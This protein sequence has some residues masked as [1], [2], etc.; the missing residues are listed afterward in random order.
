MTSLCN[1]F[2]IWRQIL[3][4]SNQVSTRRES[5]YL[6]YNQRKSNF[7]LLQMLVFVVVVIIQHIS[8]IFHKEPPRVKETSTFTIEPLAFQNRHLI[9][10]IP[11]FWL[12]LL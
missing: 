12:E 5:Q 10:L 2:E 9:V 1:S 4:F 6:F 3:D 11:F 8:I 7:I